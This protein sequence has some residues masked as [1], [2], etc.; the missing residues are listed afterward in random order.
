MREPVELI[1]SI[2]VP[3]VKDWK[4][5]D[6]MINL[7]SFES[8]NILKMEVVFLYIAYDMLYIVVYFDVC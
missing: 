4:S 2:R 6:S 8:T 1:N 5:K 7:C 3:C